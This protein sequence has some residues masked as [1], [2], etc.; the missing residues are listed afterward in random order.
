[1]Q[2]ATKFKVQ[3]DFFTTPF[4]TF[5]S[6]GVN[7]IVIIMCGGNDKATISSGVNKPA[8]IDGGDGSD[9]LNGGKGPNIILGG[10]GD[11]KILG[12][13]G[14]DIL[15]GGGGCDR[16]V[17][18]SG[19]DILIGGTTAFD[20]DYTALFALSANGLHR[21]P[22]DCSRRQHQRHGQSVR[23]E[24]PRS[25]ERRLLPPR[26]RPECAVFDDNCSDCATGRGQDWFFAKGPGRTSMCS[27]ITTPR[28][29]TPGRCCLDRICERPKRARSNRYALLRARHAR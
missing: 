17:G 18:N 26:N 21:A 7:K 12:G 28:T 8:L 6:A 4:K 16:I 1:M 3:S 13:A 2:G 14:N 15:I 22:A 27:P 20:A 5:P 23:R 25:Q 9:D 19:D 29:A 10:K 11:D 24:L